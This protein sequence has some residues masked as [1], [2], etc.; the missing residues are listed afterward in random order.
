[1]LIRNLI[2]S[3]INIIVCVHT[4]D[5]YI[6][7][8]VHLFKNNNL[9]FVKD[10]I[11][12]NNYSNIKIIN[13]N[14]N[15]NGFFAGKCRDIGANDIIDKDI[16]FFDEDKIPSIN[17]ISKINELKNIYDVIVFPVE[18]NDFRKIKFTEEHGLI[19]REYYNKESFIFTSGIYLKKEVIRD[20]RILN[21]GRIFHPIFDGIWG[22]EDDFL[23]DEIL[24]LGYKIGYIRDIVLSGKVTDGIVERPYELIESDKRRLYLRKALSPI[25]NESSDNKIEWGI[26]KINNLNEISE[27]LYLHYCNYIK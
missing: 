4:T 2:S 26:R 8:F 23:G 16:L 24:A 18:V 17:P 27:K 20:L 13:S 10:R 15:D 22:G 11:N 7:D 3:D 6:L 19:P 21:K 1:M 25:F 12:F 14:I 9:I 5:N